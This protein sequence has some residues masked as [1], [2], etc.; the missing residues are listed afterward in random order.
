[1]LHTDPNSSLKR[2]LKFVLAGTETRAPIQAAVRRSVRSFDLSDRTEVGWALSRSRETELS[3]TPHHAIRE[4]LRKLLRSAL[5]VQSERL[6]KFLAF[7]VESTLA[8]HADCI[9]EYTIGVEAYGRG[10]GFDPSQDSIVR[11]E[12]RRLRTKLSKY[13]EGEGSDDPVVIELHPG[14]Y[15]PLF[16]RKRNPTY[17]TIQPRPTSRSLP[18][19]IMISPVSYLSGDTLGEACARGLTDEIMHHLVRTATFDVFATSKLE[20]NEVPEEHQERQ[21]PYW[22]TSEG[23]VRTEGDRV[24]VTSRLR[25]ADGLHVASWR[26]DIEGKSEGLLLQL[27]RIASEIVARID[28]HGMMEMGA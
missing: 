19:V 9:K 25:G 8:D 5:F 27:E 28:Q 1:M 14:S 7:A 15:V 26:F 3:G 23:I 17:Q 21:N 13:Y 20:G 6:S 2:S 18:R 10:P 24:R 11:T 4:Q 22:L 12:A 16:H